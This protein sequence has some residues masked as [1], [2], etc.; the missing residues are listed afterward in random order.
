MR[1]TQ[2]L[3]LELDRL[4]SICRRVY[5]TDG[6]R[7][8]NS[9]EHSW[10]LALALLALR[11]HMPRDLDIDHAIRLALVHDICEIGA[12][13]MSVYDSGRSRQA[14]EEI[15]YMTEFSARHGALVD[16]IVALWREFEAQQT[17]ES[18]WV[19]MADRLVPLLLNLASE[20]RAWKEQ[21]I[22]RS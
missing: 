5:V 11:K 12:G 4:K 20:G 18:K 9:A 21:G 14:A 15:S 22:S 6:S 17:L 19:K 1:D 8:E 2:K 3:L 13:D 7:R 10:H 16:E